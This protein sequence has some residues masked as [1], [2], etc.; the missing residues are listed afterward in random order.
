MKGLADVALN[1][2]R[3]G[4]AEYADI[5]ISRH[6]EQGIHARNG[7]VVWFAPVGKRP[8]KWEQTEE[9]VQRIEHLPID[10]VMP[11]EAAHFDFD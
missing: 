11:Y 1:A 5:R 10:G 4:G 2:A 7:R 9:F 6:K 8:I 3:M